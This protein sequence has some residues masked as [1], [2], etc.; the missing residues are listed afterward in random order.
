[1]IGVKCVHLGNIL[2]R[3]KKSKVSQSQPCASHSCKSDDDFVSSP[4]AFFAR[5]Q[6]DPVWNAHDHELIVH[7]A[8]S[9]G[10]SLILTTIRGRSIW[11]VGDRC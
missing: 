6:E 5:L 3:G 4:L 10:C 2:F 8:L 7:P 11:W 1:M 9:T